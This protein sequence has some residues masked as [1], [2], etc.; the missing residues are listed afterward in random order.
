MRSTIHFTANF[1]W[2][3]YGVLLSLELTFII[4]TFCLPLWSQVAYAPLRLA[5]LLKICLTVLTQGW[6][7]NVSLSPNPL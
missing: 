1:V 6:Q 7:R 3:R 4:L 2:V 5:H